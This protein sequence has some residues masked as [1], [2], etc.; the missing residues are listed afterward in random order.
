MLQEFLFKT[1]QRRPAAGR[2]QRASGKQTGLSGCKA[3]VIGQ[4]AWNRILA[5]SMGRQRNSGL[6]M[7]ETMEGTE[8][9]LVNSRR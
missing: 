4:A 2:K 8:E 1:R 9:D 5:G 3:L 7:M 6:W